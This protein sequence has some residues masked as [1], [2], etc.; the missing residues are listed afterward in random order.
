MDYLLD[1]YM[2]QLATLLV[3]DPQ[4]AFGE[5]VEVP[6]VEPALHNMRRLAALWHADQKTITLTKHVY[7]SP[8]QVGRLGDFIPHIYDALQAGSPLA[9][10]HEGI[11]E[12]GDEVIGKTRFN[13]LQSPE[14]L[15][16]LVERCSTPVVVCGLTTP[17][18][19]QTTV[20]ALMMAGFQ[21]VVVED[22]CASQATGSLSAQEAHRAAI[23]RMRYLFAQVVTT[24]ELI[25]LVEPMQVQ[26]AQDRQAH[27][28]VRNKVKKALEN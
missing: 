18:C 2:Y 27:L 19:V 6:D 13:A 8:N 5:V 1:G 23:E 22:A 12:A 16:G 4:K 20:D 9:E 26:A 21:V 14:L 10:F 11:Y 3:V 7:H 28:A 24:D 15:G 17:I 25:K